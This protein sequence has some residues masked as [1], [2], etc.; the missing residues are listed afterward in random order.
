MP[1]YFKNI[2]ESITSIWTGMNVTLKHL[3]TP[4]ITLQYPE[5]RWQMPERARN[6]LFNDMDD[7]I[8]CDQCA[9][10]CPV[11]CI[12][13]ETE[14]VGPGEDLGSTSK[15]T[16]KRL[17]LL[18]FDI[19]MS[20]CCYCGLCTYPCPTECLVMTPNYEASVYDRTDLIY[21]YARP[22]D[23][24]KAPPEASEKPEAEETSTKT[25][26]AVEAA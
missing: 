26:P 15:G 12:Y 17:K 5:E 18:R 2:A 20:L 13:I 25:D 11:D 19:D 24:E 7:C 21:R 16:K 10:A 4:S 22:Q 8:G 1:G 23:F 3:F 9:R 14:K 6:Q